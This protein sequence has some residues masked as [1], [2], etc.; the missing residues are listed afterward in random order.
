ME[1]VKMLVEAIHQLLEMIKPC[2]DGFEQLKKLYNAIIHVKITD[3]VKK[4]MAHPGEFITL[5]TQAIEAFTKKDFHGFGLALGKL[6]QMIFLKEEIDEASPLE[7]FLKGFLE[8]I[9]EKGSIEK[10]M[11]CIKGGEDIIKEIIDALK[12]IKTLNP[13]KVLEGVKKLIDAIKKLMNLLKPCME[14]F[15]QL[16]KLFQ[17]IMHANIPEIVKRI[18]SHPVEFIKA[19]TEAI[20]GFSHKDYHKSG[21]GV[22][23]LLR[24]LFL[25]MTDTDEP[26]V[27]FLKGFLEGINEKGDINKLL[28]CVKGGEEIINKIIDAVK[29]IKTLHPANILKGIKELIAAI[30]LMHDMLQPCLE[31]FAQ[32]KK[33]FDAVAHAKIQDVI[34]KII[35]HPDQ[36]IAK[37]VIIIKCGTSKDYNCAGK[38]LGELLVLL[39]L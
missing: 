32:L 2:M 28:K 29:L 37:I 5:I 7:D 31:G 35:A 20:E 24:L 8:G 30:K 11:A 27:E 39:F 34:K 4:I 15:D 19:I 13:L 16:K 25:S 26:F 17:A 1:G 18:I 6:L 38:A 10:L 9:N 33:I 22:G 3:V 14:G 21:H 36:F 23:T 12:L